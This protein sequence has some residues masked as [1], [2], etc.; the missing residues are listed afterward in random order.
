MSCRRFRYVP[1]PLL[2]P[3]I[4]SLS[5][6]TFVLGTPNRVIYL[7]GNAFASDSIVT[8]SQNPCPSFFNGSQTLGF[9]IPWNEIGDGGNTYWIQVTNP[10]S[11]WT[12]EAV[13]FVIEPG[14]AS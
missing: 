9:L 7:Y 4:S 1:P 2:V 6:G 12:S 14:G 11:G 3:T 8:L 10:S 5:E 13:P